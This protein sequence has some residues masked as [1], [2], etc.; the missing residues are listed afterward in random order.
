VVGDPVS[1]RIRS[2]L[3]GDDLG[4]VLDAVQLS[5]L[6]GEGR[7]GCPK[8]KRPCMGVE[9]LSDVVALPDVDTQAWPLVLPDAVLERPQIYSQLR[10]GA[11]DQV[12]R[13]VRGR[14]GTASRPSMVRSCELNTETAD[15]TSPS[16]D[17]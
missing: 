12:S 7:R 5:V 4:E 16:W 1:E 17:A 9:A 6:A 2:T 11:A 13:L 15:W 14:T 10:C 8:I 3:P